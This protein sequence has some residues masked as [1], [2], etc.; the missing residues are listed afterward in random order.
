MSNLKKTGITYWIHIAIFFILTFGIGMLP[1]FAQITEYGMDILGIFV[2]LIYAWTFIGFLWPSLIGLAVMGLTAYAADI[3]TAIASGFGYSLVWQVFFM[4]LFAEIMNVLGIT[5]YLG[6]WLISRNFCVGRPWVFAF[7]IFTAAWILGGLT[8]PYAAAFMLWSVL[9]KIFEKI[10]MEKQSG[11]VTYMIAGIMFLA[12]MACM[13]FPFEPYPSV[14]VALCGFTPADLPFI[15]WLIVGIVTAVALSVA[16]LLVGKFIFRFDLTALVHA[17]DFGAEYRDRK[18]TEDNKISFAILLIFIGVLVLIN[19]LPKTISLVALLYK[20]NILGLAIIAI[21][22]VLVWKR[23]DGTPLTTWPQLMKGVSWEIVIMF[24]ATLPLGAAMESAD[25]GVMA[26]IMTAITPVLNTL[27]PFAFVAFCVVILGTITQV[28]HNLVLTMTFT[29]M[30]A[31]IAVSYGI[32]PI[33]VGFVV[34]TMFQCAT[35]TPAA[36]AQGAAVYANAEWVGQ[37]WAYLCGVT[38]A[39]LAMIVLACIIYPLGSMLF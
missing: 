7:L 31:K 8:S 9:Y 29:P 1:P 19:L 16:Y 2:G 25:S 24:A 6:F 26:S 30:L 4:M 23:K 13:V 37:K 15:P 10:G 17:G 34:V 27:S 3:N 33:L 18:M 35:A 22:F 21:T 14:I 32:D 39:I 12:A 36:S 5:E 11:Y 20:L 38:F 28:V